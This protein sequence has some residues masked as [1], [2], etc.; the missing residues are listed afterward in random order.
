MK[1]ITVLALCSSLILLP[2]NSNSRQEQPKIASFLEGLCIGLVVGLGIDCVIIIGIEC[3]KHTHPPTNR[4]PPPL[5]GIPLTNSLPPVITNKIPVINTGQTGVTY[6]TN[7]VFSMILEQSL[8]NSNWSSMYQITGWPLPNYRFR[9]LVQD[10]NGTPLL[11][12]DGPWLQSLPIDI[13]ID[14]SNKFFRLKAP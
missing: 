10:T 8:D 7:G 12:N 1:K 5:P 2:F 13:S 14:S 9:F 3:Y 6:Y 4:P 11:T